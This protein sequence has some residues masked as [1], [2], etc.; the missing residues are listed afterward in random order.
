MQWTSKSSSRQ[1]GRLVCHI[2]FG[3]YGISQKTKTA[4]MLQVNKRETWTRRVCYMK[5]NVS[6]ETN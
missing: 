6:E 3:K 4:R 1:F 2:Y 5:I